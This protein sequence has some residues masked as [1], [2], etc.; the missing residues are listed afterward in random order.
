LALKLKRCT[1]LGDIA[2]HAIESRAETVDDDP[3]SL[4]TP[5]TRGDALFG[6]LPF[7]EVSVRRICEL[8]A[9]RCRFVACSASLKRRYIPG[10]PPAASGLYQPRLRERATGST[11]HAC[12]PLVGRHSGSFG[13]WWI[14]H[15]S[16]DR[17]IKTSRTGLALAV[18]LPTVRRNNGIPASAG[19]A[20]LP[21]L[22][23]CNR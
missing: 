2:Y 23:A 19:I 15:L 10:T 9:Q 13:W 16:C 6:R 5:L 14:C 18:P 22:F 20:F 12:D 21:N 4:E 8:T 11:S 3:S 1:S 17:R 7:H